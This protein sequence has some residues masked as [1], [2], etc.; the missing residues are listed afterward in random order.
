MCL[1]MW[2]TQILFTDIIRIIK[3]Q[4]DEID[5]EKLCVATR[6]NLYSVFL[7]SILNLKQNVSVLHNSFEERNEM[8]Y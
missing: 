4:M 1:S 7:S 3:V 2:K 8:V 6:P 5:K